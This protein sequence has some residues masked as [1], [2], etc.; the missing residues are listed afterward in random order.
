MTIMES[1]GAFMDNL[2]A[3]GVRFGLREGRLIVDA[4]AGVLTP[5]VR[6]ALIARKAAVERLVR[7]ALVPCATPPRPAPARPTKRCYMCNTRMW[8][9]RPT[10]GWICDVCHPLT[11][12]RSFSLDALAPVRPVVANHGQ[13]TE[14][15]RKERAA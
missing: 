2:E 4:P 8:R 7:A 15:Q 11:P 9:E 1:A 5:E 3:R 10:G 14:T 12:P 13:T 6:A